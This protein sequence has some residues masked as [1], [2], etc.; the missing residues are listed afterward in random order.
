MSRYIA[1][2]LL[3]AGLPV[4]FAAAGT[5]AAVSG[6]A[7]AVRLTVAGDG[8]ALVTEERAVTVPDG[9]SV[10]EIADLPARLEPRTV[11]AAVA[12]GRPLVVREQA[13]LADLLTR[14]NLLRR[15]VGRELA[16]IQDDG[17][18]ITGTLLSMAGG[19]V[20]R[21]GDDIVFAV[22]GR[23]ALPEL[24]ADLRPVPTLRWR[25][26]A[27]GAGERTV[28]L[29]YVTGGLRWAADYV[30]LL[31]PGGKTGRLQGWATLE[32]HSG[33]GF[34]AARVQLLA[35]SLHRVSNLGPG[36]EPVPVRA[37]A[38]D[39]GAEVAS[40]PAG[41]YHL[42]PLPRPLDL[43][44][45]ASLQVRLLDRPAV[46]VTRELDATLSLSRHRG[47]AAAG[48][49]VLPVSVTHVLVNDAAH[50]LG[51]PLPAGVARVRLRRGDGTLVPLGEDRLPD[52]PV[53]GTA[54]LHTGTA[55]DVTAEAVPLQWRQRDRDTVDQ[56]WRATVRNGG[57][58]P[59]TVTLHVRVAAS[60]WEV[61]RADR[62][63]ERED[64]AAFRFP[65]AVPGG[66][67][68]DVTWTVRLRR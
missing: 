41:G 43:P 37:I 36:P 67:E 18:R 28:R 21:V 15:F 24:P 8:L 42:Y 31:T 7:R 51:R 34:S 68:T 60:D 10:L 1:S 12:D 56:Q 14:D 57:E 38:M 4:A 30:L 25:I 40:V 52:L 16:W 47:G 33:R 59:A 23:L 32:N 11:T 19:P 20:F 64:A 54:R 3:L 17:T 13:Y 55:F 44:D 22:P 9:A 62:T 65:L 6:P 66:D 26:R 63:W 35:G 61:L 58:Q 53:N 48:S 45:A 39:A 29:E 46:R 27:D 49:R 5:P 2:L 50:G